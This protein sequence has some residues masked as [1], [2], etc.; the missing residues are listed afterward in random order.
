MKD[1]QMQTQTS[2]A[3]IIRRKAVELKTGLS[4]SYIY[5]RVNPK[6]PRFD[7]T[8]PQAV[9]LGNGDNPPVG[10]VESEV[11]EWI[12]SRITSRQA[13]ASCSAEAK[14]EA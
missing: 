10:W 13:S 6:S 5:D 1:A 8:F 4:R 7:P 12:A 3:R 14:R 11:D 2:G 9:K